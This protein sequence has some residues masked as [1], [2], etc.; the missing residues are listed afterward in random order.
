M[1]KSTYKTHKRNS[2]KKSKKKRKIS[3]EEIGKC[4]PRSTSKNKC[5]PDTVYSELSSK[6][7][8][9]NGINGINGINRINRIN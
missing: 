7:K 5:L 3:L 8:R 6:L 2:K 4:H 9:N 1:S